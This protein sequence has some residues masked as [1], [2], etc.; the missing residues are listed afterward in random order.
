MGLPSAVDVVMFLLSLRL[1]ASL[2]DVLLASLFLQASLLLVASI[3][4]AVLL[5]LSFLLL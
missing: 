3:L 4:L 5:L 2:H 1:L